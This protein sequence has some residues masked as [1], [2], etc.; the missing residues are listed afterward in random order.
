MNKKRGVTIIEA[1]IAI[2]ILLVGLLAVS[3]FFPLGLRIISDAQSLTVATNIALSKMEELRLLGYG[4][5]SAGLIEAKQ[6]VSD[7]P[8][9]Y[10]Y[11][12]QRQTAV[13][14]V[15]SDLAPADSDVGLK[16]IT[17]NVYWHSLIG[18]K[19]KSIEIYSLF[20]EY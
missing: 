10:L 2:S 15:D 11:R 16:K 20:S 3:E 8:A 4:E 1:A 17:I 6:N 14:L 9:S 5:I 18:S 7:N 13:S 19:E 12:Y